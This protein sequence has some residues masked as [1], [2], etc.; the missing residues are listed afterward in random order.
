M[1]VIISLL[2]QLLQL[3]FFCSYEKISFRFW[4]CI[5]LL[6]IAQWLRS[7]RKSEDRKN[8]KKRVFFSAVPVSCS[9]T[10]LSVPSDVASRGGDL[11][12]SASGS[13]S[14]GH[15]GYAEG[16][17][18]IEQSVSGSERIVSSQDKQACLNKGSD[19]AQI[20]YFQSSATLFGRQ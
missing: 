18:D 19:W 8:D 14:E 13:D 7:I 16:P 5:T 3:Y 6:G 4:H 9:S 15:D 17:R 20:V 12:S 11:S 1:Q 2:F 10:S